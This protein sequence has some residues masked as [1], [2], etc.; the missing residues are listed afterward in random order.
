LRKAADAISK[1]AAGVSDSAARARIKRIASS[2]ALLG[3]AQ[4]VAKA[5]DELEKALAQ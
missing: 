2:S 3:D 5:A 1:A 4:G